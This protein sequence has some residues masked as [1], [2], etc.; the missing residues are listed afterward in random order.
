MAYKE[1]T[2]VPERM[3]K[4][5]VVFAFVPKFLWGKRFPILASKCRSE[6]HIQS[7]KLVQ[8]RKC[9]HVDQGYRV[10][11]QE[12]TNCTWASTI[13]PISIAMPDSIV[14]LSSPAKS[15]LSIDE[16]WLLCRYLR[17]T[18]DISTSTMTKLVAMTDNVVKLPSPV[19]SPLSID[20]IR[21]ES[22]NLWMTGGLST[23]T[24]T[25]LVD[26]ADNVVNLP[27]P[28]KSPLSIDEIWL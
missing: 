19:K 4:G 5:A 20:V 10:G 21:L 23:S 16:I 22:M 1:V 27:S 24:M 8:T 25:R 26:L 13:I 14:K 2:L 3:L 9:T 18:G 28:V 15:P 11:V 6:Y 7:W 12:P 17:V